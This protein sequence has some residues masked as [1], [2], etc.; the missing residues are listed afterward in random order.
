MLLGFGSVGGGGTVVGM[1]WYCVFPLCSS[2][3]GMEDL[4]WVILIVVLLGLKLILS[5]MEFA[6]VVSVSEG[7]D[8][9]YDPVVAWWESSVDVMVNVLVV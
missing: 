6:M 2:L 9:L 4:P 8:T 3:N 1:L 7:F 5:A